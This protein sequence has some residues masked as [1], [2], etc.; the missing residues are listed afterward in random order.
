M[1]RIGYCR[2]ILVL[3]TV[4]CLATGALAAEPSGW[5]LLDSTQSE[6][7]L[8]V[9]FTTDEQIS[10]GKLLYQYGG[11]PL[12]EL[13]LSTMEGVGYLFVVDTTQYYSG[14]TV[15]NPKD[16]VQAAVQKMSNWDSVAFIGV[17]STTLHVTPEFVA[18]GSWEQK[19][20]EI[21]EGNEG[22]NTIEYSYDALSKA[23]SFAQS[24][25]QTRKCRE[26][27]LIH[28]TDGSARGRGKTGDQVVSELSA[29]P[30]VLPYYCVH[31]NMRSEEDE[32]AELSGKVPYG[33]LVQVTAQ[34]IG[35]IADRCVVPYSNLIYK[36]RLQ[37]DETIH[38]AQDQSLVIQL[39][40]SQRGL[41]QE[42]V[43]L[44]LNAIPTATPEP[45]PTPSPTPT[46][47][48]NPQFV[49]DGTGNEHDIWELQRI[50]I[51][52]GF[53]N[54]AEPTGVWDPV[55][56]SAVNTYYNMNG[57]SSDRIPA[58]GGMTK[59]AYDELM[60]G[61]AN[62]TIVKPTPVP[63]PTPSEAPTPPPTI[64]P[65]RGLYI[66]YD[67]DNRSLVR[68]LNRAL[69]EKFY[70]PEDVDASSYSDATQ[71]AVDDFYK[72]HPEYRKPAGGE[73]I[74]QQA[75]EGLQAAKPKLT[76]TPA[77]IVTEDP[78]P[79]Y[80]SYMTSDVDLIAELNRKLL[81][82]YFV[83]NPNNIVMDR[84]NEET[85]AAVEL[86]YRYYELPELGI[87]S[88]WIPRPSRG[89][90]ITREAYDFLI[91]SGPVPTATPIPDLKFL[92]QPE[93]L[94][95]MEGISTVK[96]LIELG[97]L[98]NTTA[99]PDVT[100]FRTAM[101]WFAQR[102]NVDIPEYYVNNALYQKLMSED[103]RPAEDPPQDLKPGA[104]EPADQITALQNALKKLNYFRDIQEPFKPGVFDE[105]TQKAYARFCD[106]NGISHEDEIVTWEAQQKV[107]SSDK[108]NPALDLLESTK[109]FTMSNYELFGLNIPMWALLAGGAAL[110]ILIIVLVILLTRKQKKGK[111]KGDAG[112]PEIP[113]VFPGDQ[114]SVERDKP[115]D[116]M[117]GGESGVAQ[118][119]A[120][121]NQEED[122]VLSL[123]ITDSM[124]VSRDASYNLREDEELVIG[125]GSQANIPLDT[126]DRTISR[127]HGVF[128]YVNRTIYYEDTSSHYTIVDG[129]QIN[130]QRVMLQQGSE[131]QMGHSIIK[132]QW[133]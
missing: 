58:R 119:L 73:G 21:F 125:R 52:L 2:F 12:K 99:M 104:S 17:T 96:R 91:Q 47:E 78:Y 89:A 100:S 83:A 70:L 48:K 87:P 40:G 75:F 86:F 63:T 13:E 4:L 113:T 25:F 131:L 80:I 54:A 41:R 69:K 42:N 56:S 64:D 49:G 28:I 94:N 121:V 105:P 46:P 34:N 109:S 20:N 59:E 10:S 29:L 53:L 110:V 26:M 14:A 120:T 101:L 57:I 124:G 108:D 61:A 128:T 39:A 103:A 114:I 33:A 23:I 55:T 24:S 22:Q 106:V 11:V 67:T 74:T 6:T 32:F 38:D 107:L 60:K 16:L 30:F 130:Q 1:K 72:D 98:P 31:V 9:W 62:N 126:E 82:N 65:V 18:K 132:V 111:T 112:M 133:N 66:G 71:R 8:E 45:T 93:S 77:P 129:E 118:D 68:T 36:G 35:T 95:T 51:Q 102:N 3:M 27:V 84:Y 50:L 79:A 90:G 92:Y 5:R 44:N 115:T 116:D 81:D 19:Y 76:P 97:Y 122:C 7:T 15:K 123:M 88:S 127:K 37:M 117:N 43:A 85:N